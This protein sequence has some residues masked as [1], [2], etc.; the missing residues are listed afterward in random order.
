MVAR[1][2]DLLGTKSED[3]TFGHR[4]LIAK[5]AKKSIPY[6]E[7]VMAAYTARSIPAGFEPGLEATHFFEPPNFTFPFGAHIASVEVDAETGEVKIE[8]YVA[9][10]D[11]GNIIN[12]LLVAG[13]LHGGI[14]QGIGQAMWEELI[15]NEDGQLVTGS[16][17]DYVVPKAHFF[18]KFT[19]D[20]TCTPSPVNP[21]GVKGVG[22]AGTIASTPC[23]VNAV[24]D[25]LS[26]LGVRHIEMPLKP[27]RVWRAI[28]GAQGQAAR[29]QSELT[30]AVSSPA[31][32][33]VPGA[34]QAKK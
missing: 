16:M 12:P 21:M 28:S 29:N 13:Q 20:H 2:A 8:S 5:K 15:Y 27:D 11:C 7:L 1:D 25:A 19:L 32:R 24:C 31:K 10:D 18:P 4:E 23:M 6:G 3:I 26:P 9:V 33:G 34:T 14:A 17:M 30:K 22:E